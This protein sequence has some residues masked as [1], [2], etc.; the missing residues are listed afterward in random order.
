MATEEEK[1]SLRVAEAPQ[2]DVGRGL[3]RID[4]QD[5]ERLGVGI[6]DVVEISG[7]RSTVARAM[8]AYTAQ[9]GQNLIQMDGILRANAQTGLD[10]RVTVRLVAVQ[11]ARNI[12]LASAQA[13][14]EP[15][16]SLPRAR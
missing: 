8:P 6:G 9:R 10:D 14:A 13:S 2:K 12:L 5:L 4:P 3:V 1:L 16:S 15:R 11:P 7:K